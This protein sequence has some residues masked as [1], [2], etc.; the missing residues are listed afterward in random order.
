MA[1]ESGGIMAESLHHPG[2]R[3]SRRS[4]FWRLWRRSLTIKR[5]QAGLAIASVLVGAAVASMLLNLY[6][7]VRR[8]MTQEF[9]A[10]GP[11][12][13]LAPGASAAAHMPAGAGGDGLSGVMDEASATRLAPIL[14][15]VEGAS[16]VPVLYAVA[17]LKRLPP[18]P[19]LQEFQNLMAVGADFAALRRLY[20]SWRLKGDEAAGAGPEALIGSR[21]AALLH[22]APGDSIELHALGTAAGPAPA[23]SETFRVSGVISTGASEDDQVFVPL[24]A[25][26]KITG[27]EGKISLID[28]SL[29]GEA[30]EVERMA[31]QI[32][33]A[34]PGVEA[35]PIRQIVYSS[36]KVLDTIRWL[37]VSLTGLI[38]IIIALSV[39][40]TMTTIVLERQKDVAVMKALG[41]SDGLVMRLFLS[42]GAGLGLVGALGGFVLGLALA[43]GVAERLFDVRLSPTWWTL[44]AVALAGSALA[45]AATMIPVRIVRRVQPATVLKGE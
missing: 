12:V 27:L 38:L 20:P 7:D 14:A 40:A 9:R 36:G 29:P 45:V 6:G 26:Q 19:R 44:P 18:D 23:P 24:R 32:A 42:E 8:K 39:T 13:V 3:S 15:R 31:R 5:P 30:A 34:L 21:V 1:S 10:Y 22:L 35:R 37:T 2:T 11:N 17:E 41:A 43:R 33:A 4:M 28:L 16:R 25:L